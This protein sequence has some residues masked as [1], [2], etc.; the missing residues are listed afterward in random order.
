MSGL[1]KAGGA[2]ASFL[3]F[4]PSGAVAAGENVTEQV[5]LTEWLRAAGEGDHAASDRVYS[6]V[7][8][9]L[10]RLAAIQLRRGESATLTPTALVNEAYL[11]LASRSL[12]SLNDRRHFFNLA[13]R[14]MRQTVVDH[15]RKRLAE[16][17]GGSFLHTQM[18]DAIPNGAM[19]A[20]QALAIEQALNGLYKQDSHL[21]ETF[22]WRVFA[23]LSAQQIAELRGVTERTVQ[24]DITMARNYLRL[25]LAGPA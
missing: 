12:A 25:A 18:H 20:Q 17:R 4:F 16:K 7:Y 8:E 21:A 19:D 5:P 11:K 24:R 15:A 22:S 9:E 23:G 6:V 10:R 14:A 13:A 3:L 2:P 1:P